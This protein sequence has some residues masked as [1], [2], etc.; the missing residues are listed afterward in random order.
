MRHT[1]EEKI[2]Y[3]FDEIGGISDVL[4]T[5]AAY[6][7][8]QKRRPPV[9]KYVGIAASI[10][11][12][13]LILF[14]VGDLI[15][16]KIFAPKNEE[17]DVTLDPVTSLEVLLTEY[18]DELQYTTVS[19]KGELDLFGGEAYLVWQ[20]EGSDTLCISRSLS[21]AEVQRLKRSIPSGQSVGE[22]PVSAPACR[23]W[24]VCG[25]GTV[26]TPYLMLTDGNVGVGELFDYDPELTPSS[27][28]T[29]Y[30]SDILEQSRS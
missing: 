25:D 22:A 7:R 16:S 12:C 29:S 13:C 8:P 19:S 4:I 6:Y 10:L 3:L 21:K 11:L 15:G 24:I 20:E 14:R 28:F 23:V 2:A 5:E 18:S 26:I 27:S 9:L 30:V 17:T 1:K